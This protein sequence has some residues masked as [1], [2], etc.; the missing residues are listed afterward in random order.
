MNH[1][2]VVLLHI[3]DGP[4]AGARRH[5]RHDGT[6]MADMRLSDGTWV[7]YDRL[8]GQMTVVLWKETGREVRGCREVTEV[9]RERWDGVL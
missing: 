2:R 3:A 6:T 1:E 7:L 8:D 9:S 5:V 4:R